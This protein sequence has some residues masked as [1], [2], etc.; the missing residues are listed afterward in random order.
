MVRPARPRSYL[1]F[2]KLKAAARRQNRGLTWLGRTRR[3]GGAHEVLGIWF[4]LVLL[5]LKYST[6]LIFQVIFSVSKISQI[7]A[8]FFS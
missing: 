5:K 2:E 4:D 7:F 6:I 3:A 1:D 8:T